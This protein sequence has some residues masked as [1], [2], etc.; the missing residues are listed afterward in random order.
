[1]A[2]VIIIGAG[3]GG[4]ATAA[5]LAKD[6]HEV[7][8]YEQAK[9]AGGRAGQLHQDGF[10][11]DTGPS[12]YLMPQVFDR[13]YESLGT[14]ASEQLELVK[15]SP[16]YKVYSGDETLTITGDLKKDAALFES[17]EPG[18]GAKLT[19]YVQQS[20][21]T[22][23]LTLRHFL[24]SN[25]TSLRPFL[26]TEII[27]R[28]LRMLVLALTPIHT[29]IKRSFKNPHLQ[30]ILEYQ[31][32]FLGSSPYSAP[33]LYSLM[34]ALDFDE[35]VYYPKGTMY[36]LIESLE[37]LARARGVSF[38]YGHAVTKITRREHIATGITLDDGSRHKADIVISNA[39]LHFTET[40]LLDAPA[41]SY[42][43]RYW[44][45]REAGPSALLIFLGIKGRVPEFEHHTLIFSE[46]WRENFDDIFKRKQIPHHTSLY[47]SK[48][49]AT[50]NT[51]PKGYE[52]IFV[53]VPLPAGVDLTDNEQEELADEY[54]ARIHDKTGV[55][56]KSRTIT[57]TVKGPRYFRETFNAWDAT[58]LGP[59]HKLLQSAFFRTPNKSKKL[60][61]LFYVGGSTLPGIGV[62][63]CLISAELVRERIRTLEDN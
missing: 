8:I 23:H 63:M 27:A 3:V 59:S 16:A 14:S 48:T 52:N 12:W 56:L 39:D 62:P 44:S 6:G 29:H 4:L 40:K 54:L 18:A 41:R 26:K 38:H 21:E 31:M 33:A 10:T 25:F 36:A 24:Y 17:F 46:K 35:G 37:S 60:S 2:K 19:R 28:G 42:P 1:M 30:K 43:A 45:S 34:S 47:I 11:F 49:S 50:D 57:R 20:V 15:L 7:H 55:D 53:L 51:A 5:L 58:M 13:F 22:Y 9:T 61:N 32:V